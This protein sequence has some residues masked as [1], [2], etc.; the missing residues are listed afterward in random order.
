MRCSI[1]CE[2]I[3]ISKDD[4]AYRD[5][6]LC[7]ND[8]VATLPHDTLD[9]AN[10]IDEWDAT[11]LRESKAKEDFLVQNKKLKEYYEKKTGT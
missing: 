11:V 6:K 2:A 10:E 5:G 7:L 9:A 8:S 1:Q 4:A 3:Y